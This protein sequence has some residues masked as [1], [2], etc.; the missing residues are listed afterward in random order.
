MLAERQR[1]Q[2][3]VVEPQKVE[4]HIGGAPRVPE[5]VVELRPAG[6][7]ARDNLA[8]KN[9]LVGVK[10]AATWSGS[11]SKRVMVLPCL[12]TKQQFLPCSR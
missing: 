8:I 7:V 3:G 11:A 1:T 5:K 6:F 2:V 4:S 12:E 9:N 10:P